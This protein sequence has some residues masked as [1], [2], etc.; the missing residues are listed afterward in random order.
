M[1]LQHSLTPYRKRNSKSIKELK[2]GKITLKALEEN[3][4]RTHFDRNGSKLFLDP[5]LE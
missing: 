5:L 1:K 3:I 4:G 2:E